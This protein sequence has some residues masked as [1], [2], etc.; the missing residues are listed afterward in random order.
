[1]RKI[2]ET[3]FQKYSI[4]LYHYNNVTVGTF[5]IGKVWK[6]DLYRSFRMEAY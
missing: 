3:K 6:V 4:T 1:M 2:N 5:S